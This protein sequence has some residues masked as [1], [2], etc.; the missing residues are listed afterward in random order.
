MVAGRGD[1]GGVEVGEQHGLAAGAGGEDLAERIDDRAVAGVVEPTARADPVDARRRRPGS[2]S[3]GPQQRRPVQPSLGGP[4]GDDEVRVDVVG[5][6]PELVGEA[7]VVAD[8]QRAAQP[9]DLDGDEVGAGADVAL[10]VGVGERMDL[11]VPVRR[12][13]R[14]RRA[15]TRSTG[16][17]RRRAPPAR[18]P[19]TSRRPTRR[20]WS[21]SRTRNCDDGPPSGSAMSGE[22]NENP[23]ENVSVTS[24]TRAPLAA[25]P[26]IIGARCVE[27]R[28]RGR[29]RRCR[30]GRQRR[31]PLV[32]I[33]N[34]AAS[35]STASSITSMR[36]Q[37]ANRTR[38]RPCSGR[39]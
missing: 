35:R 14:G 22:S 11:A 16:A 33:A 24:T 21:P 13:R 6:R 32:M 9:V 17:D 1:V 12:C 7:Q 3:P 18:S 39:A 20:A 25:A 36:L 37:Q 29:A 2:R 19:D 4:V 38:C 31:G 34:P 5:Q 26:A 27:V 28:R 10:L 23:V 8:E 30:A 15:R